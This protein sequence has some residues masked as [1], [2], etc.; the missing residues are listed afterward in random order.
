MHRSFFDLI[1]EA[2]E[3]SLRQAMAC[4]VLTA[5]P[6]K[7]EIRLRKEMNKR[8]IWQV[9]SI[10]KR[11]GSEDRFLLKAMYSHPISPEL[12]CPVAVAVLQAK[13]QERKRIGLELH[14]NV[15]QILFTC[16]LYLDLIKPAL[17]KDIELKNK[18]LEFI[19]MAIEEIRLLSKGLV[20]VPSPE[21]GLIPCI[22]HLL[23]ELRVTDLFKINFRVGDENQIE[24]I[25]DNLKLTL[26][27]IVQE[28]LKNIIKYSRA[29]Q[30]C[31][32]LSII[33][34]KVHLLIEDDGVGFDPAVPR[35]GIGLSGICERTKIYHGLVDIKTRP[36]Q[37]CRVAVVIPMG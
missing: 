4:S 28:Q 2:E 26:F 37:G 9:E 10:V 1:P 23:E 8:I 27:R 11:P 33:D 36:G 14:D 16:K 29:E 35:K 7:V 32:H 24:S 31:L 13:E 20:S 6:S 22:M 30:V 19:L 17:R 15:N 34:E 25:D 21:N 5:N 3:E 18:T 12:P